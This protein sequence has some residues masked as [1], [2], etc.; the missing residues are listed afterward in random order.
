MNS[1][2]HFDIPSLGA[3]K[4]P[5][6]INLSK[7]TG[8][9]LYK[10]IE[11]NDRIL[12]DVSLQDFNSYIQNHEQPPCLEKAGPREKLFFD[13]KNTT[14]DIVTCGELSPGINNVIR[15]LVMALH[16]SYGTE[17]IIGIP[18][19]FEGLIPGNGHGFRELTP[20]KVKDIHEFGGT[21]LGSSRGAHPFRKWWIP[22]KTMESTSCS[23]S[24]GTAL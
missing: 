19:G 23:L 12:A 4:I 21:V 8:H 2:N 10:F 1:N 15:S 16:Y 5:S 3:A 20:D 6:P 9:K 7:T 11:E 13:P 18:Y 24:A 17:R 22:L 14:A